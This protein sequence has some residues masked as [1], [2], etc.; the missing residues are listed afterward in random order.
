M[1]TIKVGEFGPPEVLQLVEV[2]D[3]SPAAGAVVIE[4]ETIGLGYL[5]T[6]ARRGESYLASSPG[7]TPGYEVAGTV[8]DIGADVEDAWRGSRV[9]AVLR[10]GGGC[11]EYIALPVNE[12]IPLPEQV[13]CEAAV[14]T[15]LNA[16]VAQVGLARVPIADTDR[17]LIRG[18]GGG[19][20]LMCL[21]Y[22][23]LRGGTI[24]ATTSSQERG[25]R[26]VALGASSIWNR[27]ASAFEGPELFD[28][29]VDT[30]VGQEF[31]TFFDRIA[32]NGHYLLCGA[33]GGFPP[34]DFGMKLVE[35]FHRSPTLHAFSLNSVSL[36]DVAREADVLFQHVRAGRISPIIDSVMP[37]TEIVAAHRKLDAGQAFGKIVLRPE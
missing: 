34:R 17:I 20:G 9:F 32:N 21:Q 37:L 1:K 4:I 33:V 26:L 14:A 15:G 13:S 5:D 2:P 31:P 27:L 11:A 18:A 29:I 35:H 16:L 24:V 10:Q 23:A 25:E 19:I 8:V 6:A 28:V 3:P 30:V 36:A 7:F 12:L 22:A